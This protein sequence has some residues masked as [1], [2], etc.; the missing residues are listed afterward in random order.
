MHILRTKLQT[1]CYGMISPT[2]EFNELRDAKYRGN[3][4]SLSGDDATHDDWSLGVKLAAT[5][6]LNRTTMSGSGLDV[7]LSSLSADDPLTV[8]FCLLSAI[9]RQKFCATSKAHLREVLGRLGNC[10]RLPYIG[11]DEK[12]IG[13]A[14]AW[15]YREALALNS[16]QEHLFE[17]V[18]F[19][20]LDL[21]VP[22]DCELSAPI[23]VIE[24]LT[25]VV[26]AAIARPERR[27]TGVQLAR[28][29][30]EHLSNLRLTLKA[31]PEIL[32]VIKALSNVLRYHDRV[33]VLRPGDI[34][35]A[36][37]A[38]EGLMSLLPAANCQIASDKVSHRK[39][40][41]WLQQARLWGIRR[42][43]LTD[44]S[45]A[46]SDIACWPSKADEEIGLRRGLSHTPCAMENCIARCDIVILAA[47]TCSS[48]TDFLLTLGNASKNVTTNVMQ[49][50]VDRHADTVK[51]CPNDCGS[52]AWSVAL[53]RH[54]YLLCPVEYVRLSRG[55]LPYLIQSG[56]TNS[57][58][59]VGNSPYAQ[60]FH[61]QARAL[62]IL[63]S[64]TGYSHDEPRAAV[65][66]ITPTSYMLSIATRLVCS[67]T[68]AHKIDNPEEA[69]IDFSVLSTVIIDVIGHARQFGDTASVVVNIASSSAL[70]ITRRILLQRQ[71]SGS[72]FSDI[73][74][75][76]RLAREQDMI[77]DHL[78]DALYRT[79]DKS[80][81]M[82][83]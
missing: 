65:L 27:T 56:F 83:L 15:L 5:S 17:V 60:S 37:I 64:Q 76:V 73:I 80:T 57:N 59:C 16:T 44:D 10:A 29:C 49:E 75:L 31:S 4:Q 47:S 70:D 1:A 12:R 24:C 6:E 48:K 30:S 7:A 21:L 13:L 2:L 18:Q 8:I 71:T 26:P 63:V 67:S 72:D 58:G 11:E 28:A 43:C 45:A 19:I 53:A 36:L 33:S 51:A 40:T 61:L 20:T 74:E 62:S 79:I 38:L 46:F 82:H 35:S 66:G 23:D 50:F 9:L 41:S 68:D 32:V 22:L 77:S 54:M 55:L 78:S 42:N 34:S 3:Q 25:Y 69:Q 52:S 81:K 14:T 39:S